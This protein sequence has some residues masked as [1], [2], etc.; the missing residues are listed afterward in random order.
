MTTTKRQVLPCMLYQ[1][2]QSV[3]Q[4]PT[5]SEQVRTVS[6]QVTWTMFWDSTAVVKWPAHCNHLDIEE[7][8][9]YLQCVSN[10]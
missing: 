9:N 8:T 2:W 3:L 4:K 7:M 1:P 5:G 6:P 10:T